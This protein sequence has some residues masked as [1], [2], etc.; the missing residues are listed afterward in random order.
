LTASCREGGIQSTNP[1][2]V[3][4]PGEIGGKIS[5]LVDLGQR[6][7]VIFGG[8]DVAERKARTFVQ[9]AKQ[10]LIV[11]HEFRQNLENMT[12]IFNNLRLVKANIDNPLTV[13]RYLHDAFIA[14][15][16]TSSHELNRKIA[17]Q[18]HSMG[19]LVNRVDDHIETDI[20]VPAVI[21]R[22]D[23]QIAVSTGGKSPTFSRYLRA[24]LERLL[25]EEDILLMEVEISSRVIA[26]SRISSRDRR[27]EALSK[28][29]VDQRV[30]ELLRQKRLDE[31]KIEAG[32]MVEDLA[33]ERSHE[34]N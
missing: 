25:D 27:R 3:L 14:I 33:G 10:V 2:S 9:V 28:I 8:G 16:A 26:M 17:D 22:G 7:V 30:H 11:S 5:L 34:D 21:R 19:K 24:K 13:R 20:I 15:P 18:A 32:K 4:N 1:M 23:L 29:I 6:G 12:K 31:A